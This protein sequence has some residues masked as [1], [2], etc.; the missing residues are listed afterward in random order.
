MLLDNDVEFETQYTFPDLI[1]VGG[2]QLR[3]D[4][5]IFE[6]GELKR[7]IEYN[8]LQHYERTTGSW[9][10]RYDINME[11]DRRKY[12]YCDRMGIELKIIKYCD[13]YDLYDLIY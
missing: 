8:G 12:E 11:N 6:N 2:K 5:A 7:L 3:F 13:E 10:D 1:G 9:S 4:F